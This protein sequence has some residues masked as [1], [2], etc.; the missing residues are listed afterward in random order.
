[1]QPGLAINSE[2]INAAATLLEPC[3][4]LEGLLGNLEQLVGNAGRAAGTWIEDRGTEDGPAAWETD[5]AETMLSRAFAVAKARW[6]L[7]RLRDPRTGAF[8]FQSLCGVDD[9]N[10]I[11]ASMSQPLPLETK[12]IESRRILAATGGAP[13]RVVGNAPSGAFSI[14]SIP[15]PGN[16][17]G[18]GGVLMLGFEKSVCP[19][20]HDAIRTVAEAACR[21]GAILA[22]HRRIAAWREE[23]ARC[24]EEPLFGGCEER[25]KATP[26][27]AAPDRID[28]EPEVPPTVSV[29]FGGGRTG[30]SCGLAAS[31]RSAGGD[32]RLFAGR[33]G[34]RE[35]EGAWESLALRAIFGAACLLCATPAEVIELPESQWLRSR[36][37]D[38]HGVRASCADVDE[39]GKQYVF[40]GNLSHL[41][42]EHRTQ[43]VTEHSANGAEVSP[44]GG[45]KRSPGAWPGR[46][47]RT[48][49][50]DILILHSCILPQDLPLRHQAERELKVLLARDGRKPVAALAREVASILGH[51]TDSGA[52]EP[53]LAIV[54]AE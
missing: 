39:S 52:S 49:S 3:R 46:R 7:L 51:L 6:A 50:G 37:I 1:L 11:R 48:H 33:L 38:G 34:I 26:T 41:L 20:S 19:E 21:F 53:A 23:H 22:A 42:Y 25:S 54:R 5:L 40:A 27:S 17:A 18:P 36:T 29:G 35:L 13:D 31:A 2:T 12:V 43:M 10:A 24:C 45:D 4:I 47:F 44:D 14:V 32:R 28:G 8:G 15:V 9:S 16:G 30:S